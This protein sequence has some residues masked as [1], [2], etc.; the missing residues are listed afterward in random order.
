MAEPSSGPGGIYL[1]GVH[2]H[3]RR[4]CPRVKTRKLVGAAWASCQSHAHVDGRSGQEKTFRTVR[5]PV[6]RTTPPSGSFRINDE[7][8]TAGATHRC[9]VAPFDNAASGPMGMR[10]DARFL[11]TLNNRSNGDASTE[12]GCF[13]CFVGVLNYYPPRQKGLL[14]CNRQR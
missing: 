11:L 12:D 9:K 4:R 2:L 6:H 10:R 3:P 13:T 1:L 14:A 5:N 7:L 8:R